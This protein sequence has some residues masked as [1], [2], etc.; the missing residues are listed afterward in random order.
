MSFKN[1][2]DK[3]AL[4]QLFLRR[5]TINHKIKL[6]QANSLSYSLLYQITTK[7][8]LIIKEYLLENLYKGFIMLNSFFFTSY[9]LFVTKP[10]NSLRFCINYYKLNNLT[11]KDQHLLSLINKTLA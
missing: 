8:L 6:T 2:C 11:K 4:D 10:N 1:V 3:K 7:E 5:I 9:I